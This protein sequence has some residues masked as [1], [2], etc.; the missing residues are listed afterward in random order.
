MPAPQFIKGAQPS[1]LGVV[2]CSEDKTYRNRL[3]CGT[4]TMGLVRIDWHEAM[5]S[6]VTPTNFTMGKCTPTGFHIA[7]GQNIIVKQALD[8]GCEWLWLV[9]D[10]TLPPPLTLVTFLEHARSKIAPVIS[11]LYYQRNGSREP[12][13]YR[14][15]GAYYD[16][17]PGDLVW[18]GGVPTG[19][20]FI[21]ASIL[22]VLWDEAEPYTIRGNGM[23]VPVR[24]VFQ[25]PRRIDYDPASAK[26]AIVTGTSDLD[27]CARIVKDDVFK[28][29]GWPKHAKK[30][31]PFLVDTNIHCRHQDRESGMI[32]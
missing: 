2:H 7:D 19:C 12:L 13:I 15:S 6:L 5:L 1:S 23:E 27:L 31:W 8:A 21:H 22:R 14:E 9:E 11:G 26:F 16:W 29:A 25:E 3:L 10:D 18:C 20:L 30:K 32:F 24:R 28:K 17:K 4:V